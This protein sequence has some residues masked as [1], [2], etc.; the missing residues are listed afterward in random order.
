MA[1]RRDRGYTRPRGRVAIWR[2]WFIG[3]VIGVGG[4]IAVSAAWHA[5]HDTDPSCT[6]CNVRHEPLA[7]LSGDLQ[8]GPVDAPGSATQP[9]AT[10]WIPA[11]PDAQVPTRA[12]PLS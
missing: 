10:T 11:D 5:E 6:V 3:L 12:P 2:V 7:E 1:S 8:V 9:S 4:A